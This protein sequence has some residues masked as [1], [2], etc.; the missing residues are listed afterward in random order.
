MTVPQGLFATAV[1]LF[2]LALVMGLLTLEA[3]PYKTRIYARFGFTSL[4][5]SV[6]GFITAIWLVVAGL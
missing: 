6:V 1:V 2:V 3:S 5:L 4:G